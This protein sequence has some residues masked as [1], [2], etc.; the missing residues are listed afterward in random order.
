MPNRAFLTR[1]EIGDMR[2]SVVK[3]FVSETKDFIRFRLLR[4]TGG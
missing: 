3:S 4:R 1:L 2:N